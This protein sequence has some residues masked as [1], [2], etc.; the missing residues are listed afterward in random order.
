MTAGRRLT[1]CWLAYTLDSK[2][3]CCAALVNYSVSFCV[4]FKVLSGN[5]HL[6]GQKRRCK[7]VDE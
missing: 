1:P 3:A 5:A 7:Q 6:T 2:S 4:Q